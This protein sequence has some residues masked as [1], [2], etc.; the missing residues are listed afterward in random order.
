VVKHLQKFHVTLQRIPS[1]HHKKNANNDEGCKSENHQFKDCKLQTTEQTLSSK[2]PIQPDVTVAPYQMLK[3]GGGPSPGNKLW[4]Q[5]MR[6]QRL[7]TLRSKFSPL[8]M[9]GI[10]SRPQPPPRL[11]LTRTLRVIWITAPLPCLFSL[12]QKRLN[13]LLDLCVLHHKLNI[14]A[15]WQIDML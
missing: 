5:Q 9:T 11:E 2:S 6:A 14:T 12:S 3:S 13:T 4:L 8:V 7:G 10:G 1:C 15:K